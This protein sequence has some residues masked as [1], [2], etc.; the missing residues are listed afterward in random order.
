MVVLF[1]GPEKSGKSTLCFNTLQLLKNDYPTFYVKTHPARFVPE[2]SS[3]DEFV[4]LIVA[5][6][7][8]IQWTKIIDQLDKKGIVLVDRYFP[9]QYLKT[10]DSNYSPLLEKY[11]KLIQSFM[12]TP[13]LTFLCTSNY[14][15]TQDFNRILE[16]YKLVLEELKYPYVPVSSLTEV[17]PKIKEIYV[18]SSI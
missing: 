1:E 14:S 2:F 10:I 5:G 11:T 18:K 8:L 7:I 12:K 3:F 4:Q 9:T 6:G 13:T 16:R 15:E 17:I